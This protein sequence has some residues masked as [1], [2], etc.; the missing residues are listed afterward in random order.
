MNQHPLFRRG[1]AA[2]LTLMLVCA[3]PLSAS[4]F[5]W[6]KKEEEVHAVADFTKN[7]L[8]VDFMSASLLRKSESASTIFCA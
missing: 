1:L 6:D 8:V 3:L 4:A 5:F 7:G 2:V